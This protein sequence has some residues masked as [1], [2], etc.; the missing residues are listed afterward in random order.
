MSEIDTGRIPGAATRPGFLFGDGRARGGDDVTLSA[1]ELE[2]RLNA[3]ARLVDRLAPTHASNPER[4]HNEKSEIRAELRKL[5]EDCGF[6]I[7]PASPCS[8]T[9]AAF[10]SGCAAI[11]HNGKSIPI[12]RRRIGQPW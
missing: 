3:I 10:D 8:F 6:R 1:S 2:T 12:E 9:S 7:A 4:W 5:L 11:R